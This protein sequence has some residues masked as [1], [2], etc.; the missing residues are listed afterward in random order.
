MNLLALALALAAGPDPKLAAAAKA[1][2][3]KLVAAHPEEKARIERGVSQVMGFWRPADG[4][5][6]TLSAFIEKQ[7]LWKPDELAQTFGRFESAL[8]TLDRHFVEVNR[9]LAR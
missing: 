5:A 1:A 9:D 8:E 3:A 2:Q 4:D 6:A 7:F